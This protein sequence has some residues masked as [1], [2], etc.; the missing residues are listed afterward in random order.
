MSVK[1]KEARSIRATTHPLVEGDVRCIAPA[2][3]STQ[4]GP[5]TLSKYQHICTADAIGLMQ[6]QGYVMTFA[7]QQ[8][9]ESE[10]A[11]QAA[12]H[13]IRMRHESLF[14]DSPKV[15][16]SVPE[17][18][19]VNAGDGSSQFWVYIGRYRFICTNGLVAGDRVGTYGLRHT[20]PT[21][22]Q[23]VKDMLKEISEKA[24]PTMEE[25]VRAMQGRQLTEREQMQFAARAISLR[26][27][28]GTEAVSTNMVLRPRRDSDA[29]NDAWHVYNRVQENVIMGGFQAA[30]TSRNVRNLEQVS[31]VV[32]VNRAMW[33]MAVRLAA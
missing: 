6:E 1:L 17:V 2:A 30:N 27:P 3:F 28:E 4:A 23:Q 12:K 8:R 26:W 19:F 24:L 15:G 22:A 32:R 16:D 10:L 9:A 13:L 25:Q 21:L 5:N 7:A 20:G 31:S 33:D 29:A 18:C 14:T 11:D